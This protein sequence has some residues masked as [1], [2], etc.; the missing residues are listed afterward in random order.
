MRAESSPRRFGEMK[1]PRRGSLAGVVAVGSRARFPSELGEGSKCASSCE[2]R[3]FAKNTRQ[4]I[5]APLSARPNR[6]PL[7][8]P[9]RRAHSRT[10][11][12]AP[13]CAF[14]RV[15][16]R[17]PFR[18]LVKR[19]GHR[20]T[21]SGLG[22]YAVF[23]QTVVWRSRW[24][25]GISAAGRSTANLRDCCVLECFAF[26]FIGRK[27][28]AGGRI[29]LPDV[30][31][32]KTFHSQPTLAAAAE[33]ER[34]RSNRGRRQIRGAR[35]GAR[36]R[37]GGWGLGGGM[38]KRI[39]V[40]VDP[41]HPGARIGARRVNRLLTNSFGQR[42][43]TYSPGSAFVDIKKNSIR[44]EGRFFVTCTVLQVRPQ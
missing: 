21:S 33:A 12:P 36:K 39:E 35:R 23:C 6:K 18:P 15:L 25:V 38:G 43:I 19:R 11:S 31:R 16:V 13:T 8:C 44:N 30:G 40:F 14:G 24:P 7:L 42:K 37:N 34:T 5:S 26:T 27:I 32:V 22:D 20:E 2:S 41:G 17:A 10:Q 1:T 3:P 4:R 28:L 29:S 9:V